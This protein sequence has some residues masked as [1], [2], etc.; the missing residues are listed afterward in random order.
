MRRRRK[1]NVAVE[2]TR[3]VIKNDLDCY[4]VTSWPT[5][6]AN[7]TAFP[8]LQV[9]AQQWLTYSS[10]KMCPPIQLYRLYRQSLSCSHNC[11]PAVF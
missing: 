9:M 11:D 3:P 8:M 1:I 4:L 6:A 10:V 5:M 7:K 2:N